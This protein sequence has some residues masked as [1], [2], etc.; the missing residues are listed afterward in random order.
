MLTFGPNKHPQGLKTRTYKDGKLEGQGKVVYTF[1][2]QT[3]P[4]GLSKVTYEGSFD[5]LEVINV[6]V[7]ILISQ[8][9]YFRANIKKKH[10]EVGADID[11]VEPTTSNTI[12]GSTSVPFKISNLG[13]LIDLLP[14]V[15]GD[16]TEPPSQKKQ[17][18]K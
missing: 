10:G 2:P 18:R 6:T 14:V 4:Q 12:S 5:G 8:E 11:L 3:H 16:D 13:P 17:R 9:K 1:D 7:I 15:E